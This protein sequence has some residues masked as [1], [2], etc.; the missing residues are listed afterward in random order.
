VFRGRPLALLP[1]GVALSWLQVP[2]LLFPF[3]ICLYRW[4]VR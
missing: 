2:R 1:A 4:Q 3:T